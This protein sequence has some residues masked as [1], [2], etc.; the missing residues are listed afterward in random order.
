MEPDQS[1]E[2][3]GE[4]LNVW[5]VG[6]VYNNE[7]MN[8][9]EREATRQRGRALLSEF[10]RVKEENL[11]ALRIVVNQQ[12]SM[13]NEERVAALVPAFVSGSKLAGALSDA[14]SDTDGV[15]DA[16]RITDAIAVILDGIGS[17]RQEALAP[18]LEHPDPR[19]RASAGCYLVAQMPDRVLPVLREVW[20][21]QHGKSAALT[22]H[23]AI[24]G[25]ELDG[26]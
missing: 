20:E 5:Y 15:W 6:F 8:D 17:G 13:P 4:E 12:A 9:V 14:L 18:L 16:V 25:W 24:R 23:F 2:Q 11:A 10:K 1:L 21:S 22:A 7:F 3:L 19:V 26:K